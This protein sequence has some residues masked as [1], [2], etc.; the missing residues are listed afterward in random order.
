MQQA[1]SMTNED[2]VNRGRPICALRSG[3]QKIDLVGLFGKL[4]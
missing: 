4:P 2:L 3:I 1:P